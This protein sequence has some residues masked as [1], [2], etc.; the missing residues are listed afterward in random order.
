MA[1]KWHHWELERIF[2][3]LQSSPSG[4]TYAIARKRLRQ[5]KKNPLVFFLLFFIILVVLLLVPSTR[6]V[7]LSKTSFLVIITLIFQGAVYRSFLLAKRRWQKLDPNL[8]KTIVRRDDRYMVIPSR[9]LAEGDIVRIQPGDWIQV[10]IRLVVLPHLNLPHS[11][12][13]PV[14][15]PPA[16]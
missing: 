2:D 1:S 15:Q 8:Q 10:D 11:S 14:G 4:I 13:L 5:G 7:L 9:S 16:T 12:S 3:V 6:S